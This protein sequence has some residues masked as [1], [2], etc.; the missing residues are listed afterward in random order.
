MKRS[1]KSKSVSWAHDL[2]LCQV[3]LFSSED[4]PSKVGLKSCEHFQ[5][6]TSWMLPPHTFESNDCPP[7][8][9]NTHLGNQLA[10]ISD[11]PLIKWNCPPKFVM[12]CHWRVTA[13]EESTEIESQN[14]REMRLLEAIYPRASDIPPGASVSTEIES[15]PYNDSLTPLVPIS[16]IEEDESEV[17]ELDS[18]AV[19]NFST[20]SV[21]MM[22][23]SYVQLEPAIMRSSIETSS[24]AA[25]AGEKPTEKLVGVGVDVVAAASAAFAVLMKSKE[26]GSLIDTN[27]LIEIFSDPTMIQNLTNILPPYELISE[28]P[29]AA[30]AAPISVSK[31]LTGSISLPVPESNMIPKL[32]NGNLLNMSNRVLSSEITLPQVSNIAASDV[33]PASVSGR[34]P[35]P[36]L[37]KVKTTIPNGGNCSKIG[38]VPSQANIAPV[39][40]VKKGQTLKDV[41]YYKN[42]VRQHGDQK[43]GL[44]GN[45]HNHHNLNMMHEMKAENLKPKN[46]KYCIYFNTAKGCRNG[47]N[48]QYKHGMSHN[49]RISNVL[50]T[51]ST[52][53]MKLWG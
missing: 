20:S 41:N 6:K 36:D 1:R 3:T 28:S 17:M 48:C 21:Q 26:Q 34:S 50:E 24:V 19:A 16:P 43:I 52:K 35:A 27:L 46:E 31:P 13:G 2:N 49:W 53:R 8:F 10:D 7:G 5:A 29:P 44:N 9:N 40:M 14:F 37:Q 25:A 45:N 15:E 12:S 39:N 47:V 33:K 32:P 30:I 18:A 42:L 38:A 11:I 51:R 4:C 23:S 22:A